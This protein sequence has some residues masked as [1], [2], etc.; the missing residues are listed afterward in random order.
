MTPADEVRRWIEEVVVGLNLCPFARPVMARL[1]V[2]ESEAADLEALLYDLQAELSAL[3]STPPAELPTTVLV[4]P[5]FLADFHD[6]L[7]ALEVV[8]AALVDA[9]LEG[10][11]QV[12][13]FHPDYVFADAE[14]DDPANRTN[15]SPL[16]AFHLIREEDVA[17]AVASHPDP[18]CIPAR[19]VALMRRLYGEGE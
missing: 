3:V 9:E 15:R 10:V 17:A 4:V 12:A 11:I 18:E 14:P 7:D 2:V 6:Y 1:R 8:E 16:P 5:H 13:S 19:N